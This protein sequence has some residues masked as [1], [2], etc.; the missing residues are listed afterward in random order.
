MKKIPKVIHYF[1]FGNNDKPKIFYKCLESWKKY[2]PDYE[3]KEWNESNFDI[4]INQYVSD[5]YKK[6]KYAFVSDYA[7][8]YILYKYGGLY[9][10]VDVELLK[11]IDNIVES[12]ECFM[13]FED[14]NYVNPGLITGA[15]K[16]T[17]ILKEILDIY[18]N[19]TNYEEGTHTICTIVTEFLKNNYGLQDDNKKIQ[20]LE[21]ITIY[22]FE[23]FCAY[24]IISGKT[25]KTKN[26][27]SIHH[28]NG[29]WLEPKDKVKNFIKKIIYC[30]V[31][32]EKYYHLKAMI[33]KEKE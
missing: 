18:D 30:L 25:Y 31:G 20:C 24:D 13:G 26:T 7:R 29:S 6:K 3:I 14:K 2:C 10:D 1:W 23:Y 32:K 8:L 15:I 21:G 33:R 4:N 5:A 17:Y 9:L 11:N 19:F 22:P 12:N 16:G 28:Y 27:Y